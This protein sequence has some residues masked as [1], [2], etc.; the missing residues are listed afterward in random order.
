MPSSS[1]QRLIRFISKS[2]ATVYGEAV[3]PAGINDLAYVKQARIIDGDIFR[4]FIVSDK[5][6]VRTP[7]DNAKFERY[8]TEY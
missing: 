3:L 1:S 2:G 6:V 5:I 4:N 7:D 8:R